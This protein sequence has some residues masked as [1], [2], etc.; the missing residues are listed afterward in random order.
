MLP[1]NRRIARK[2]FLYVLQNGKRWNSPILLLNI[3][4]MSKDGIN[5]QFAFSVSKKVA[6]L[7]V[8]RNKLRRRGYSI[9]EKK[10]DGI[11]TGYFFLF[12]Y[13]KGA[14]KLKYQKIE[15]EVVRL[16]ESSFMLK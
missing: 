10:I 7:A 13:K 14:E 15:E 8:D 16:L 1:K 9:I 4:K 11:K 12:S 3:A 6:K 2:D 5:S